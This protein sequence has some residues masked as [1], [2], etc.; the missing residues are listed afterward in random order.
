[1]ADR[2]A[3]LKPKTI[4]IS[5]SPAWASRTNFIPLDSD[6]SGGEWLHGDHPDPDHPLHPPQ[7]RIYW[8]AYDYLAD[9]PDGVRFRVGASDEA[10]DL[11]YIHW[12]V[13]GG[14]ANAL[15]PE[16]AAGDGNVNNWTVTFGVDPAEALRGTETA[17]FTVQLA[18]AKTASGNTD[19]FNASQPY[20]N[21][22]Y[23]V[24]VNGRALETWVIP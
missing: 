2:H 10:T 6:K 1:M 18:G 5:T 4:S 14:Y 15:R 3:V 20:S 17:T 21:L 19:V 22:P 12:S 24:V 13:F 7:Y 23:N 8:A 11:N 9:F 16:Q